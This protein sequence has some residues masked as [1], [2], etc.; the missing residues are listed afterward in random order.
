MILATPAVTVLK[1]QVK[2]TFIPSIATAITN[3]NLI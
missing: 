3:N 2:I 1:I